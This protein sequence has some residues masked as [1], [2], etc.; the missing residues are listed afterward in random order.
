MRNICSGISSHMN[1]T[2][3]HSEDVNLLFFLYKEIRAQAKSTADV[4]LSKI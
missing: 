3:L 4:F 1:K 2:R